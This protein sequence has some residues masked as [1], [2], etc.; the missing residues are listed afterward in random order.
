M[1][2]CPY[3]YNYNKLQSCNR[4]SYSR[5]VEGEFTQDPIESL[6]E[7]NVKL[8][9]DSQNYYGIPKNFRKSTS[10]LTAQNNENL[11][12]TGL[13]TL[14]ISG[15]QQFSEYNLS[16]VI[17]SI[18]TSLPITVIDLRQESHG[19]INGYS[20]SWANIKNSANIGLTM[21]QVVID[22]NNKLNSIKL[23]VPMTF[24]NHKNITI[25]PVKV[26]NE[27]HIITSKSLS[28]ERITV[29]DGKIPTD[30]MVDYFIRLVM[31]QPKNIWLH[32]HC[33]QGIGRTTTFMIMY[34]MIKNS[35]NVTSD[36]IIKRQQLL[37]N[38]DERQITSFNNSER[39]TFLESFYKYC[40]G[41]INGKY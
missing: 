37:A 15:S 35:Q 27:Y 14:N 36:E 1:Y 8:V 11:N 5:E 13:S 28:Y 19:F 34:D 4:R 38:F 23:N 40:K 21:K 10:S 2:C 25:V 26:E 18:E 24:Y 16:L 9:L 7:N 22:E 6:D 30:D 32:F 31:S 33:K 39:I 3:L 29:T 17:N 41:N 20:V 12:L